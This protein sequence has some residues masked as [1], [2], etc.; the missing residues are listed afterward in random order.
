MKLAT[1][2]AF[3][4]FIF[5]NIALAESFYGYPCLDDCSGHQAGYDWAEENEI[6]DEDDCEGNSNS[7]IEGCIAYV[8]ENE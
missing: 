4:L 2:V 8:E 6:V 7:L 1:L 3:I 5:Q